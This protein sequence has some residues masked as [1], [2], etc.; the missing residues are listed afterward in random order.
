M[1]ASSGFAGNLPP[2]ALQNPFNAQFF[3][4]MSVLETVRVAMW[5]EVIS[6]T[7]TGALIPTG[8]VNVQP[9]VNQKGADGT[10]IPYGTI[11]KLQYS[12]LQGGGNAV[13][14][15]PQEGDIGI[16][17]VCDRDSSSVIKNKAAANPG[18]ARK[19]D[20]A[21]GVLIAWGL[22]ATPNQYIQFNSSGITIFS[23]NNIN[24]QATGNITA[25]AGGN[26]TANASGNISATAGGSASVIAGTTATMTAS[27]SITLQAPAINLNGATTN[28]GSLAVTGAM[29]NAGVDVGQNHAHQVKLVQSG[30]STIE[31]TPPNV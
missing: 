30:T 24:I 27:T 6:C 14:I 10:P 23:P 15:D 20:I 8:T 5:V 9:L 25:T 22:N 29:T 21:D 31:T 12:R 11:Y 7:N 1:S 16:C 2:E 18:S 17:L 28:N 4:I 19:F 13:I 26:I 3:Q